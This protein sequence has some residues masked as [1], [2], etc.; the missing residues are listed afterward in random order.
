MTV[1]VTCSEFQEFILMGR[2]IA[3]SSNEEVSLLTKKMQKKV[4]I[5]CE[6]NISL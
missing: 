2:V 5:E 4:A 3:W 6:R 1:S